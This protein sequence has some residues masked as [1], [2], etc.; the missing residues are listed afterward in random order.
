MDWI[1]HFSQ[2]CTRWCAWRV[3]YTHTFRCKLRL[4]SNT[5]TARSTHFVSCPF[6]EANARLVAAR[7]N[8]T[9][10][11]LRSDTQCQ[12]KEVTFSFR[13]E[14]IRLFIQFYWRLAAHSFIFSFRLFAH[15]RYFALDDFRPSF[16]QHLYWRF[17]CCGSW[18]YRALEG[19]PLGAFD[20]R[21]KHFP[22]ARVC[23][24]CEGDDTQSSCCRFFSTRD[25][26][27]F[28]GLSST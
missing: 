7:R 25:C 1:V 8:R 11:V 23:V 21:G 13:T 17:V 16:V 4:S 3:Q 9:H 28:Y 18:R 10:C 26:D 24:R 5:T 19:P 2:S 12:S 20:C 22:T 27:R 14:S 15:S 6:A